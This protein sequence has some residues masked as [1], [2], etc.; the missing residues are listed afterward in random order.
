MGLPAVDLF[1]EIH[2]PQHAC[3]L[4]HPAQLDLAPL[5][6]G[7][8]G[9]QGGLQR[10]RG[11]QQL[12]IGQAGLL[13]LLGQLAVLLQPVAFEQGHLLLHGGELLRHRRQR[14]EHTAVLVPGLA[15]LPVLGREQAP[16]G[17]GGGELGADVG[18]PGRH[19]VEVLL[20]GQ[21]AP[22]EQDVDDGG[23]RDGAREQHEQ[24]KNQCKS[25]HAFTVACPCDSFGSTPGTPGHPPDVPA[26]HPDIAGR[27]A[28]R[29]RRHLPPRPPQR[30]PA[31][32]G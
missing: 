15:E 2:M 19:A 22:A 6:A 21:V 14:P 29:A 13:Q 28:R 27:R 25:I 10:M 24:G 1:V 17:V 8:V 26:Q 20:H 32:C 9:A 18:K 12:L 31:A 30:S 5:A 7:A 16:L 3:R 11:P 23:A 4:D